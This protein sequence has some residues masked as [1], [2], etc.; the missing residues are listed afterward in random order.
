MNVTKQMVLVLTVVGVIS[1]LLMAASDTLTR[2]LIEQHKREELQQAIFEVLPEAKECERDGGQ[3]CKNIGTDELRVYKGL[4]AA[5]EIAGYAFVAEGPGFQ[6]TI[7]MMIGISPDLSQLFS[8]KVLAQVETP[9]LGARI[10]EETDKKDFFEQFA[11]LQAQGMDSVSAGSQKYQGQPTTA[12]IPNFI[13]SVKNETPDEPNEIQ[14]ITGA[15]I[16]SKA[17]VSIINQSLF[18]LRQIIQ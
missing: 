5:N 7:Q 1:S 8:M 12:E 4:N 18:K 16:S 15:T 17:V 2:P 3:E 10:A 9:G 6:G 14:A 11:G 13:Q